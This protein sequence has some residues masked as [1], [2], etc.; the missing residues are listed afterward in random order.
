MDEDEAKE[1][2]LRTHLRAAFFYTG[3]FLI[4]FCGGVIYLMPFLLATSFSGCLSLVL[5]AQSLIRVGPLSRHGRLGG[6]LAGL[7]AQAQGLVQTG[8]A[9]WAAAVHLCLIFPASMIFTFVLPSYFVLPGLVRDAVL[10]LPKRFGSPKDAERVDS[11]EK[12]VIWLARYSRSYLLSMGARAGA[13]ISSCI[14]VESGLTG[15]ICSACSTILWRTVNSAVVDFVVLHSM[16]FEV[17]VFRVF[18]WVQSLIAV[19]VIA[20]GFY[21]GSEPEGSGVMPTFFSLQLQVWL[22]PVGF[23]IYFLDR[24]K[25]ASSDL[26][27]EEYSDK[28]NG[29]TSIYTTLSV[30]GPELDLLSGTRKEALVRVLVIEPGHR[31]QPIRCRLKVIDLATTQSIQYE[32]LS[33]VWVP[34]DL[35]EAIQVNHSAFA[36]STALFQALLRLRHHREPRAIWIDA[37]CINQADLAERSAQVLLMQHIYSRASAVVVWL[38]M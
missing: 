11:T 34:P 9:G 12:V 25:T 5:I 30:K 18:R 17:R 13:T 28:Q 4:V 36:V 29:N 2:R 23:L 22:A 24:L 35:A 1:S 32:A 19:I 38:H 27:S 8:I 10:G 20:P 33:Y 15:R 14:W 21:F 6:P 31:E 16:S 7:L 26:D 3:V 37:I